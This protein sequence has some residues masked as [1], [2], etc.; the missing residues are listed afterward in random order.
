M[1]HYQNI[2][3]NYSLETYT[4]AHMEATTFDDDSNKTS[5]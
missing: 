3:H 1:K 4:D 2:V 5:L